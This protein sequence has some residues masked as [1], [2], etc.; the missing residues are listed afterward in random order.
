MRTSIPSFTDDEVWSAWLNGDEP[1]GPITASR[2]TP[3][4]FKP[5]EQQWAVTQAF[6]FHRGDDDTLRNGARTLCSL[7]LQHTGGD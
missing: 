3:G 2:V 5:F 4:G 7:H 1:D 6:E